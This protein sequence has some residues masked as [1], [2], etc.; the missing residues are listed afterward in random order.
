VAVG[1]THLGSPAFRQAAR[2]IHRGFDGA[3]A[4]R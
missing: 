4:L 2:I 3:P 1:R